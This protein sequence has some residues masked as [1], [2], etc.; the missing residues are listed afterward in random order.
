MRRYNCLNF[1]S[2]SD[3]IYTLILIR[4]EDKYEIMKW[5]NEQIDILRQNTPLTSNQQET[6]F[7]N[8]V[9]KLFIQE[10]PEQLLFSFL[11]NDKLIGYGGLVHIDWENKCAEISFLT[12]TS[13]NKN[14]ELFISDWTHY[15]YL[16]KQVA[17]LHLNFKSIFTYAYDIRPDLYIALENCKFKE[18]K[19]IK[20]FIEI[21]NE[22]KDVVIHTFKF[23]PL[24]MKLADKRDVDLYFTWTND[25]S[26]RKYSYQQNLVK[27]DEHVKWF[28]SKIDDND[29]KYYLFENENHQPVGQVRINKNELETIVGIS[30]DEKHRGFGYGA[31]MLVFACQNYFELFRINRI[32]AYIKLDNLASINIFKKAGFIDEELLAVNGINSIKLSLENERY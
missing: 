1:S 21:D 10:Y 32:T 27:Y 3:R 20:N 18:T 28:N 15:I 14:K 2:L 30:I 31:K 5:R 12:E 16:I 11:E 8:V 17:N 13:R 23:S 29:F 7:K 19:R 24:S 9:D 22:L 6:Y 26:V 4:D 25:A